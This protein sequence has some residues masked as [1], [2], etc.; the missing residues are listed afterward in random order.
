VGQAVNDAL[1]AHSS[2]FGSPF[3]VGT[4]QGGVAINVIPDACEAQL[5]IRL[6]P[7]LDHREVVRQVRELGE[8]RVEVAVLG[9]T[10]RPNEYVEVS[11]L[12]EAVKIYLLI[13]TRYLA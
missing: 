9:M 1:S 6:V 8:G 2:S 11:R 4:L 10:H 7:G 13:A 3:T 5:D 12:V